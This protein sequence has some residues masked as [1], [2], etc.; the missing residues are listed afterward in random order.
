MNGHEF[1][2]PPWKGDEYSHRDG[3]TEVV[4]M[5]EDGRVLTFR[6]YPDVETFEQSVATAAYRGVNDDVA[7]LPEASAFAGP[8][9]DQETDDD[10]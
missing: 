3:T 7:S 4:F 5:T 9:T 2:R 1:N 10:E 8:D 6:E